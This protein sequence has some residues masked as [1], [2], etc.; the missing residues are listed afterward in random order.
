MAD[1]RMPPFLGDPPPLPPKADREDVP[2]DYG[3]YG[4]ED[5]YLDELVE[6]LVRRGAAYRDVVMAVR[7]T[8]RSMLEGAEHKTGR[9]DFS[10]GDPLRAAFSLGVDPAHTTD[11]DAWDVDDPR[12]TDE[13]FGGDWDEASGTTDPVLAQH[14]SAA[15]LRGSKLLDR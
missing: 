2:N 1:E 12:W 9:F 3:L 13:I 8:L 5:P 14:G 10:A 7:Q 4:F 6:A 15:A 11:G